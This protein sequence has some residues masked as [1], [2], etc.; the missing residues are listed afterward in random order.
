MVSMRRIATA[1]AVGVTLSNGYPAAAGPSHTPAARRPLTLDGRPLVEYLSIDPTPPIL[2][3]DPSFA[4]R[5]SQQEGQ[6]R[7]RGR[8]VR[9]G[10]KVGGPGRS[11]RWCRVRRLVR[12]QL[13]PQRAR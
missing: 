2:S 3:L 4:T 6:A 13:V 8:R 7:S 10:A 1:L 12:L 11:V 5:H 9:G